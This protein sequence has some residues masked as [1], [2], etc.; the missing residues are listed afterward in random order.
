MD[1][2]KLVRRG[3]L[4][5]LSMQI[6][7]YIYAYTTEKRDLAVSTSHVRRADDMAPVSWCD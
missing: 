1:D 4:V 2:R 3:E 6:R 7:A 5:A